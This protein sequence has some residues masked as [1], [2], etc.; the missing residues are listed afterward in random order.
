MPHHRQRGPQNTKIGIIYLVILDNS[1]SAVD[2]KMDAMS[3]K[4]FAEYIL[5]TAKIISAQRT[6]SVQNADKI[7]VLD[8]GCISAVDKH[9]ELLETSA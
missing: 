5:E 8:D 3:Q 2:T 1:I 6:S 7:I 9:S 4:V